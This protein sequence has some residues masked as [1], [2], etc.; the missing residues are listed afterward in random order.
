MLRIR[1]FGYKDAKEVSRII[2]ECYL[3]LKIGGHTKKGINSQIDWNSPENLVSRSKNIKYWVAVDNNEVV[4]ICGYDDKKVHTLF[5]DLKKHKKGIG[6]KLLSK[7]L[8]EAKKDG[9]ITIKTWS[10]FYAESF[11]N[12][13]GFVTK[14]KLYLPEGTKDV[15]LIKMEKDL[16]QLTTVFNK[17][18]IKK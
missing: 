3:K 12:S 5:V 4:G 6:K 2:K 16:R 1:K 14:K 8:N 9:L 13:F 17:N 7:I 11:Y 15:I 18:I 10:T